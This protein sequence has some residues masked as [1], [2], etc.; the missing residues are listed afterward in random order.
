M[1]VGLLGPGLPF[2]DRPAAAFGTDKVLGGQLLG[3]HAVLFGAFAEER[4]AASIA[5]RDG[6]TYAGERLSQ[7]RLLT[8]RTVDQSLAPYRRI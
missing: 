6:E 7:L 3:R 4:Q 1:V 2:V 8:C 5:H